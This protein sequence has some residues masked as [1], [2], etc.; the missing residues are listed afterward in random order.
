MTIKIGVP[1]EIRDNEQR[2]T[3]VPVIASR[4]VSETVKVSIETGVGLQ[5]GYP[6]EAYESADIEA[7]GQSLLG[8]S[9]SMLMVNHLSTYHT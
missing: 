3:L 9:D 6:D 2:V 5:I 1:K 7:D 8:K 4:L